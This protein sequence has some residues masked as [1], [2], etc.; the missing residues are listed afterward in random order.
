MKKD[1]LRTFLPGAMLAIVMY[2][3]LTYASVFTYIPNVPWFNEKVNA[4]VGREFKIYCTSSDVWGLLGFRQVANKLCGL[5]N[6]KNFIRWDASDTARSGGTCVSQSDQTT[7]DLRNLGKRIS[8][9]N[10]NTGIATTFIP[11]QTCEGGHDGTFKTS[12]GAEIDVDLYP[13]RTS[14]TRCASQNCNPGYFFSDV[15]CQCEESLWD[16]DGANLPA[17]GEPD[18]CSQYGDPPL[19]WNDFECTCVPR[20]SPL[21]IDVLGNGFSLTNSSNGVRFDLNSDGVAEKISWTAANSDDAWLVLDR[22]RNG[23]IDDGR[24]MFGNFSPQTE[25][26]PTKKNGFL[27]LAEYDKPSNGGNGDGVI[28]SRDIIFGRLRLWQDVNHN[29]ISEAGELHQLSDLGVDSIALD[30][31]ES[32]QTDVYGNRFTYRATVEDAKHFKVGNFAWD[33]FLLSE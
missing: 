19:I 14:R 4:P 16:D 25:P 2:A 7:G 5:Q 28:D 22:N 17:C 1:T 33:V 30:Y 32:K 24:E 12:S 31:K 27:A 10:C 6:V 13:G 20:S 21:I 11:G 23:T 29:G 9:S 18:D 8:I 3:T 15:S 26:I